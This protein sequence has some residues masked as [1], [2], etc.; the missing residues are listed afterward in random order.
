MVKPVPGQTFRISYN[1]AYV[2]PPPID[3]YIFLDFLTP[4]I[5]G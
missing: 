5:L 1:R 2:A 3:N 4:S